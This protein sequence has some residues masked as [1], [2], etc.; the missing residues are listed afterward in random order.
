[1][2][3][4]PQA[5]MSTLEA[6]YRLG[7]NICAEIEKFQ[8]DVLIGLAHSGWLPVV[9]AQTLW[10]ET[11]AARFPPAMR[12]NIGQEKYAMYHARYGK[13]LPAFCCGECCWGY[14]GRGH[15]LAWVAEQRQWQKMLRKQ[16]GAILPSKPK[17]V[18]VVDDLFGTYLSGYMVL[19]LLENLYPNIEARMFVGQNDLTD[20]LVTGW[21]AEFIPSLAN[22][23]IEKGIDSSLVRFGSPWQET[24]KPLINGTEDI[25]RD[26]LDWQFITR[27]SAAVKAAAEY[28]PVEV[29]LS[30]PQWT[31]DLACNYALQ[32]LR[33]EIKDDEAVEP[34]EDMVHLVPMTDMTLDIQERLLARAWLQGGISRSDITQIC[35]E[36]PE[37]LKEVLNDVKDRHE[38]YIHGQRP[39]EIYFPSDSFGAWANAY[40]PTETPESAKPERLIYG[41]AEFL[42]DV[43]WAGFYPLTTDDSRQVNFY[44]HLLDSGVNC[45]IDLT[46]PQEPH[47]KF[48]YRKSLL[49]AA[50]DMHRKIEIEKFPLPFRAAPSRLQV[51]RILKYITRALKHGQR[52][53]IHAGYNLE[54]RTPLILVCLLIERGYSPKRALA[55]V[56]AFWMKTLYFL[57]RSTLSEEQ[58]QFILNW[59]AEK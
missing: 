11:K 45:V 35:G 10:A 53:Y 25:E 30:A 49:Q 7:K 17:R 18:L 23:I 20:N 22:E 15:Y 56:D 50:R 9:V 40:R 42:P 32:R 3:T 54:G 14:E 36:D 46:R 4:Y 41:Y 43:V 31:K 44:K 1:M 51:R 48:S 37:H 12:T 38:W 55:K 26:S 52:V 21:L 19:G 27:E 13:S 47:G 34:A 57:I 58:R 6:L 33:N 16:I 2:I 59:K 29:A 28:I 5:T 39:N 8:P 24:F